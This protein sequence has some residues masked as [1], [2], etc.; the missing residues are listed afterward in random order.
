MGS[1]VSST[2][3]PEQRRRAK[4]VATLG[5]ASNSEQAFRQL[6]RAGLDVARLNFSHGTH[7]QKLKLIE[8]VR[9]VARQEEKSICIMGD[10]QG[11][12]IRTGKLENGVPVQL[13]AG[14]TLTITPREILGTSTLVGTTFKTLAENLETGSRIL[15]SEGLIE[16]TVLQV[17]GDAV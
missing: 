9:E 6:V 12:K 5:P 15:L 1:L 3:V 16:L 17:V 4:I 14:Q 7:E 11:P 13:V 8:M 10:L 2:A